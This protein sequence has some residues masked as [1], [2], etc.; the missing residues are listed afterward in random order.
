MI[1][2]W[3]DY[4]Y[5]YQ[6]SNYGRI[7]NKITNKV[8]KLFVDGNGYLGCTVS[9]GKKNKK[10]RIRTHRAVAELFIDNPNNYPQVNHIDGNKQNNYYQNLEWC[11]NKYNIIHAHQNNLVRIIKGEQINNSKLTQKDVLFIRNNYK[12]KNK[13]LGQRG[14]ARKFNVNEYTIRDVLSNKTW[15]I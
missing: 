6:V 1:E 10:K 7:K 14:L 8:I 12:A 4:V 2:I 5:N 3:K 9:L 15:K 11:T 13:H